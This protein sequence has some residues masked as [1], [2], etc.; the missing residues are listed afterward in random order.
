[1]PHRMLIIDDDRA[2]Q[3]LLREH[4]L[5]NGFEAKAALTGLDGVKTVADEGPFDIIILDIMLPDV[6]GFEVLRRLRTISRTP[7]IMLTAREDQ[8]DRII[9][10]E[11][12]ADD[13]MH[14][15]FNPREL[16]ARIKAILRRVPAGADDK[17][18]P[19]VDGIIIRGPLEIDFNRRKLRKAGRE[20]ALTGV[21]IDLLYA[22]IVNQGTPVTRDRLLD[23]VSGR[24]FEAFDR[25]IDVHVSRIRKKIEDDP[26][27][28]RYIKTVWGKGYVW[29]D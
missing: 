16:L 18:T 13:Y 23:L 26:S 12:G 15:P 2:L 29:A 22:L 7:V 25:S 6:D 8:T 3:Q 14:K 28:P 20:I 10:L 21:E 4:F 19:I 27:A 24:D 11:L 9:G 1:M 17:T 5:G